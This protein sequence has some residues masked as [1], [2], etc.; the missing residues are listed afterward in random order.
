MSLKVVGRQLKNSF[1]NPSSKS[2]SSSLSWS[3]SGQSVPA[4]RPREDLLWQAVL[5]NPLW[6]AKCKVFGEYK[7]DTNTITCLTHIV[8]K[9]Y[10]HRLTGAWSWEDGYRDLHRRE[11]TSASWACPFIW[12]NH[13]HITYIHIGQQSTSPPTHCHHQVNGQP[14]WFGSSKLHG[15]RRGRSC[16]SEEQE[17]GE[18][19][20]LPIF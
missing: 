9:I 8:I 16:P 17:A 6:K 10:H 11:E 7:K 15:Q 14:E 18:F 5:R 3:W 1:I 13:K 20:I 12:V 2:S 4:R 19:K